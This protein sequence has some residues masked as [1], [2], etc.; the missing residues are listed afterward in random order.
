M[1]LLLKWVPLSRVSRNVA[2]G[3][4]ELLKTSAANIHND[5]DWSVIFTLLE[6]VGAGAPPPR[7]FGES[8]SQELIAQD[9]GM[10]YDE[11]SSSCEYVNFYL[12]LDFLSWLNITGAKSDGELQLGSQEDSGI[13]TERGYT[14]DSEISR[15]SSSLPTT[16]QILSQSLSPTN[17]PELSPSNA[18]TGG[19]ILVGREGEIQPVSMKSLR[20]SACS[21]SWD[22]ELCAHDPYALI[23]CCESLTFLVRDV[24][25]ITPYNFEYCVHCIRTF[26]EASLHSSKNF[27]NFCF[28]LIT[29]ALVLQV[30]FLHKTITNYK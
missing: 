14:S 21:P 22:R 10:I 6:V 27:F 29:F 7:V 30:M 9:Q 16:S 24:A 20:L 1:L 25:H 11:F 15:S 12:E 13:G 4:H 26:V 3:I 2:Y 19:W 28:N 23:K 17:S 8:S 5:A 18:L